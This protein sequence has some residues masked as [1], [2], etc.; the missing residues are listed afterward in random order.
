MNTIRLYNE[1]SFIKEFKAAVLSCEPVEHDGIQEIK[2]KIVLDQTA[3]FP[4]G[5]G[6]AADTGW[7]LLETE[8]KNVDDTT[9]MEEEK[10]ATSNF[11][12]IN[13]LDVQE[14]RDA[15]VHYTN[16]PIEAGTR[17]Q[18]L[19]NWKERFSKM[20][21]HS[22]EHIVSGLVNKHFGFNNVGFHLGS[23]VVTLDFDGIMTKEQLRQVEYEANEAVAANLPIIVTYP[24]KEELLSIA[25]RSK[26]E[27]EGQ[28]RLVEVPGYDTCACCAPHMHTTGQIGMI[29]LINMHNYKGGVRVYMLCGFAALADY[30]EKEHSVRTI[31]QSMSANESQVVDAVERLKNE[32]FQQK[33]KLMALTNELLNYKVAAIPTGIERAVLIEEGLEGNQPREL[34]NKLL[35]KEAG[36]AIVFAGN[37]DSGYRFVIGSRSQDVRPFAKEMNRVLNGRGGGKPEMVQGSAA[38]KRAEIEAYFN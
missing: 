28:V 12:R 11:I 21:H 34:M 20:Q 9:R 25:Y 13:V 19:L 29:K 26:I 23:Q 32:I 31:A 36:T 14:E 5:G 4:E 24:T 38:C 1:D 10:D 2:Y 22:G 8:G 30:N 7:I 37:D 18:G 33:G 6:Q 15:V 27:I 35:D 3:F 17:V 16:A